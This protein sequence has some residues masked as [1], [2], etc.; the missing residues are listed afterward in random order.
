MKWNELKI[1]KKFN[2]PI[3]C[4]RKFDFSQSLKAWVA[5]MKKKMGT[6]LVYGAIP[7]SSYSIDWLGSSVYEMNWLTSKLQ[8]SNSLVEKFK[9][10]QTDSNCEKN[11]STSKLQSLNS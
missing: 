2:E 1:P 5:C 10:S 11:W 8:T 7:F 3:Q 9:F 6:D 4:T